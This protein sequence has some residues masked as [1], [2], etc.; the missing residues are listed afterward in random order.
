MNVSSD[1]STRCQDELLHIYLWWHTP[2]DPFHEF[3]VQLNE[4]TVCGK[5]TREE[6]RRRTDIQSIQP[7]S[8]STV[9]YS[10]FCSGVE[11]L[12]SPLSIFLRSKEFYSTLVIVTGSKWWRLKENGLSFYF[13]GRTNSEQINQAVVLGVDYTPLKRL[14]ILD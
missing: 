7:V 14:N 13:K 10:Y 12:S 4:L 8:R 5:T 11:L 6:K 2:K 9:K 1:I 3:C